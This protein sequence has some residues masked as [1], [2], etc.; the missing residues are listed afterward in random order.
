[1]SQLRADDI[2]DIIRPCGFYNRNADL[3]IRMSR[4]FHE[5]ARRFALSGYGPY[6]DESTRIFVDNEI[7]VPKDKIL[8]GYLV[9]RGCIPLQEEDRLAETWPEGL[10]LTNRHG[11]RFVWCEE[12]D[13]W[14]E[15]RWA[16]T[17]RKA[18]CP[19]V[20]PLIDERSTS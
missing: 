20:M 6:A 1:M 16:E 2:K 13:T 11:E 4:Q 9:S 12:D 8:R 17:W 7:F 19:K 10:E 15:K 5:G 14:R 3:I 18:G